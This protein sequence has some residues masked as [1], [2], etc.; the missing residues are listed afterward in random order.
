MQAL[1]LTFTEKMRFK[2]LGNLLRI[3][4]LVNGAETQTQICLIPGPY[5]LH[6]IAPS[7]IFHTHILGT[8][9]WYKVQTRKASRSAL[10]STCLRISSPQVLCVAPLAM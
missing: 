4:Q 1:L 10:S 9:I 8:Q 2:E 6:Y 7:N 5:P 3:T